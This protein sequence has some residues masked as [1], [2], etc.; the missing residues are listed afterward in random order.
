MDVDFGVYFCQSEVQIKTL[1][2][3]N[4]F[5]QNSLLFNLGG[6]APFQIFVNFD[7]NEEITTDTTEDKNENY[8]KSSPS[9]FVGFSLDYTQVSCT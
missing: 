1:L 5:F 4:F 7:S 9:G 2:H 6:F 8:I 3:S